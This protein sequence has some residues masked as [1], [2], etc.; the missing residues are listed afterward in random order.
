[1]H[2]A[3]IVNTLGLIAMFATTKKKEEKWKRREKE[4]EEGKKKT[5]YIGE[6]REKKKMQ[7]TNAEGWRAI[8]AIN[9]CSRHSNE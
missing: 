7:S 9:G 4:E 5:I 8:I 3:P 2:C 1:M 6:K